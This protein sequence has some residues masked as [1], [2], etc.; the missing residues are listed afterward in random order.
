MKTYG[1]LH[2]PN[3]DRLG[4]REVEIYG[5]L[6]LA[7]LEKRVRAEA[8]RLKVGLEC[9]QSNHEG[10]LIEQ[11]ARWADAGF[12]GLI[13]NPG[14]YTHTSVALRDAL[15][16]SGRP[17]VEVHLSNIYKREEFRHRS[18]TAAAC[19]GVISGLGPE[20]YAAALQF[21]ADKKK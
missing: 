6:T 4:K 16:G 7:D 3:L 17:C 14:G 8:K 5:R 12:A 20:G 10:A 2:G 9:F 11:I 21:L 18:L 1:L 19:V 15:A 13:F